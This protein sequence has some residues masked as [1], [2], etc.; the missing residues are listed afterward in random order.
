VSES[1][2]F[3]DYEFLSK[4]EFARKLRWERT[5]AEMAMWDIV[6]RP[7][8]KEWRFKQQHPLGS[9]FIDVAARSI[10]LAVEIDGESHD[11][12]PE[13]DEARDRACEEQGCVVRFKNEDVLNR[14][15]ETARTLLNACFGRPRFRY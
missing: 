2:E 13:Y 14:P 12:K 10:K 8:F 9:Y 7:E 1:E 4:T 3:P 6:H 5:P 11:N 15:D